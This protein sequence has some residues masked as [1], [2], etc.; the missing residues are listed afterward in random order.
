MC[1]IGQV[2]KIT[3]EGEPET[4]E[5]ILKRLCPEE[6]KVKELVPVRVIKQK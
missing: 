2:V 5:E 3:N 6:P 1:D 4:A